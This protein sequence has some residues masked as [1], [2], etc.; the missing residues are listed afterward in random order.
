MDGF[1]S[2]F[3]LIR[4]GVCETKHLYNP[5][6]KEKLPKNIEEVSFLHCGSLWIASMMFNDGKEM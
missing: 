6:A 1:S 5:N 4:V 2:L 3:I